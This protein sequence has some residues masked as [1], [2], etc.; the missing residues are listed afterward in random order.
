MLGNIALYLRSKYYEP[1]VREQDEFYNQNWTIDDINS[2]Q[3][4]KINQLWLEITEQIPYFY[5]LSRRLKLPGEF[6]SLKKFK[7]ALPILDRKMIQNNKKLF[8]NNKRISDFYRTT[9]GST[10]QPIQIPSCNY[11]LK[12][13]NKDYWYARS[14]F[15]ITPSDK[16][17]LIWGHTHTL[18]N[19]FRGWLNKN[20]YNFKDY[21]LGYH[22]YSAYELSDVSLARAA[23]DLIKYNP[24]Y[25]I[26]YSVALDRFVR[27]NK[28]NKKYFHDLKLKAAIATAES[29][30]RDD[31]AELI[32]EVLGCPVVME[33]GTV[34]TGP[35]AHQKLNGRYQVFW[36]HNLV[37][38]IES[39]SFPGKHEIIITTLYPRYF[40][41]IRYKVGDF[42]S[43]NQGG[44]PFYQEF[45]EV[46]GRCND[47][48]ELRD[49]S[50]IHSEAFTHALKNNTSIDSY[51]IEQK[52]QKEL[53]LYYTARNRLNDDEINEIRRKL[54]LIHPLLGDIAMLKVNNLEQTIA[55]KIKF[56]ISN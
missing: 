53:N 21:L 46:I 39:E 1:I 17:F 42:I 33:Y 9:G 16:L 38:S 13:A 36:R 11:E 32:S 23:Q 20:K 41:L 40:P 54:S 26:S 35:V 37:E 49:G 5:N 2:W 34:E 51:Q 48:I 56:V 6:S 18:G 43:K 27:V 44:N 55:G 7:E 8:N 31:S 4:K 15:G 19:G 29:F 30:P 47:F 25:I 10:G 45:D 52:N 12:Y 50:L 14:W 28:N 24:D 3:L 22:R